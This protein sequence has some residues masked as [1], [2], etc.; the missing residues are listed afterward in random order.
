MSQ[1][2]QDSN[3]TLVSAHELAERLFAGGIPVAVLLVAIPGAGKSALAK[4][5]CQAASFTLLNADSIRKE[6]TGN[7]SD[8]SKDELVWGT[9]MSRF[10]QALARKENVLVDNM[11]HTRAARAGLIKAARAAG[12]RVV[13]VF[14]DVPLAQCLANNAKRDRVVNAFVVQ[15][16]HCELKLSGQ[17]LPDE[18][19]IWLSYGPSLEQY[20]I[21]NEKP[22]EPSEGY[23]IIGDVHGCFDEL[24]ELLHTLGYTWDLKKGTFQRPKGRWPVFVGDIPDRGPKFPECQ[25]LVM[26]LVKHGAKAVPGNHCN[27]LMRALQGNKVRM[28]SELLRSIDALRA[29]REG[30]DQEVLLFLSNLPFWFETSELIVVHAAYK[31]LARGDRAIQLALYGETTG[32]Y[33]DGF[34]VRLDAWETAYMG[35]KT[36]VHGH[37]DIEEPTVRH[38]SNGGRIVNVDTGC[39]FG[40]KLTA[41]RFPEMEFISV[42]ANETYF[43]RDKHFEDVA[44]LEGDNVAVKQ[45]PDANVIWSGAFGIGKGLPTFAQFTEMEEAGWIWSRTVRTADGFTYRL[46]NYAKSTAYE[47]VW[48]A[49]TMAA[50]GLIVCEETGECIAASMEKFFNLGE[51]IMPGKVATVREGAFDVFD[52]MDGSCGIGFRFDGEL[53]WATRG[54]FFS[55]QAAV[56]QAMWDAKYKQHTELFMTEWNHITP[57]CEIIHKETRVVCVYPYEDLVLIAARNRFTGENIPYAELVKMGERM[58]MRVV[59]SFKFDNVETLLEAV[60]QLGDN[61]E[62]YVLCWPDY[63]LK[64]KGDPYKEKHRLLSNITPRVIAERWFDSTIDDLLRQMPEEFRDETEIA[65]R[66][67]IANTIELVRKT[68]TAY[69]PAKLLPDQKAFAEW[70]RTQDKRLTGILFSRRQRDQVGGGAVIARNALANLILADQIEELLQHDVEALATVSGAEEQ[71]QRA[72]AFVNAFN[73]YVA[74]VS[75]FLWENTRTPE[76]SNQLKALAPSVPRQIRGPFDGVIASLQQGAVID[77]MREFVRKNAD[78]P[79]LQGV[80]LDAIMAAAPPAAAPEPLHTSWVHQQPMI[81]RTFLDRWRYCGRKE[82]A[83]TGALKLL[84]DAV[85]NGVSAELI[86][87]LN[88]AI[89]KQNDSGIAD[90]NALVDAVK[91]LTAALAADW[92]ALPHDNDP[93]EVWDAV[94]GMGARSRWAKE[95]LNEAWSGQRAQVRDLFIAS[96]PQLQSFSRLEDA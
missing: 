13:L 33:K 17:P 82:T 37:V 35:G 90:P 69:A 74:V 49:V 7:A 25:E 11:H 95:L 3:R 26:F 77:K 34:P 2:Q 9:M 52:K 23:D 65:V 61:V 31:A 62:G 19:A 1:E 88:K 71:L 87:M 73:S 91:Q 21:S 58:G 67:L 12:H 63:R 42:P 70:V 36:I 41:L 60:S 16:K 75:N 59:E 84:A 15:Q 38:V 53:K 46:Y 83:K 85:R 48:N 86:E 93:Q 92:D 78:K 55:E 10:E 22:P 66:Q 40:R 94:D 64:V 76:R 96:D 4:L 72:T 28:N 56:A 29:Y 6:L 79:E 51:T 89:E 24:V 44:E 47:R 45:Y 5:L 8:G 27:K 80:D 18:H 30:F 68:E 81:L 54:S 32:K 14:L 50:R 43:A 39:C 20:Y 57:I